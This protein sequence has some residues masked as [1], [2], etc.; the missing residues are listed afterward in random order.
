MSG[1]N[2]LKEVVHITLVE[3][4]IK[5]P[6]GCYVYLASFIFAT[7]IRECVLVNNDL[8]SDIYCAFSI[9]FAIYRGIARNLFAVLHYL[10]IN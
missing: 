6:K 2:I 9:Q 1:K 10:N 5:E 3:T 4:D 8:C 7:V